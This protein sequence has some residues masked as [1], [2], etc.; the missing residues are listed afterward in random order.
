L[1]ACV[2]NV[3]RVAHGG[4]P[5]AAASLAAAA[6]LF[7]LNGYSGSWDASR[8]GEPPGEPRLGRSLAPLVSRSS[9]DISSA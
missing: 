3:A 4:Y 1:L 5:M 8:E 9:L 2:L 6:R 7:A